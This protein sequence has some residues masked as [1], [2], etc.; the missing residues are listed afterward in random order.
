MLQPEILLGVIPGMG[1]T[2][3]LTRAVGKSRAMEMILTGDRV[4][5][6]E[7]VAAGLASRVLPSAD[8]LPEAKKLAARIA[9][10]SLPT[11]A[12]AKECVNAAYELSLAE[13]VRFEKREFWSAFALKDQKEGMAAFVEK[14]KPNFVDA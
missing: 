10:H 2:Q 12:K 6:A 9:A 8:L 7:A 3:R 4:P 14:R 13:G 5:A 11:A 1:G